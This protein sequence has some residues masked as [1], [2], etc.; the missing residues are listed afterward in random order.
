M[1]QKAK[2]KSKSKKKTA[3]AS[4]KTLRRKKKQFFAPKGT[5][6]ILPEDQKYWQK[7]RQTVKSLAEAYG[8]ERIDTPIIE[9]TGLFIKGTGETTDI[10]EKE[11]Y[12]FRTKGGD[13][14]TLRP[15]FTPAFIRAYLENGLSSLPLPVKL[16]TI[17]PLFRYE[18]PQ[19]GRYR[20]HYQMNF[21]SV[22]EQ[23]PVLDA[24][25]IYLIFN[26]LKELGIKGLN[27]QI[28]SIGCFQCRPLYRRMLIDYFR[29]KLKMLCK[30]CQKRYKQNPLRL[31][32]C[33]E[34]KCQEIAESAPQMI[35]HLCPQCHDHFKSILEFLDELELPYFL[36]GQLVRGLDYYTRTVF[37]IWAE[38]S[39]TR[40]QNAI[41]GGG[42]YDNLIQGLGGQDTPAVG[43]GAGIERIISLIKSQNIKIQD[44]YQPKVFLV[45]LGDLGKKKSLKLFEELRRSG[46]KVAESL[47][48][49]SIKSQLKIANRLGVQ[50]A[51]ILG[52]KETLDNTI[53][54]RDMDSGVQESV[55][56]DKIVKTIK[57]RLKNR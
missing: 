13:N 14:L 44:K 10:V 51:L 18:R 24:Q 45:Q 38:E 48:K 12:S 25:I 31:L 32:D 15:E 39:K 47:S 6:D 22:G 36:N 46:I 1:P 49:D 53:I 41:A 20:Q 9:D 57:K 26:I 4:K 56:M 54:I 52:Q 21:E 29:H 16:Y 7:I 19:A 34:E 5:K 33:K 23:D 17:G 11:M 43:A 40:A 37:E 35:D 28:N 3:S 2:T 42:R 30:R 55:P 27:I 8:F 50:Y